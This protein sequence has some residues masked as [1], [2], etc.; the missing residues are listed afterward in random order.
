MMVKKSL[1]HLQ[2]NH[3][4]LNNFS[5]NNLITFEKNKYQIRISLITLLKNIFIFFIFI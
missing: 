2:Q 3:S 5:T 1:L 4:L